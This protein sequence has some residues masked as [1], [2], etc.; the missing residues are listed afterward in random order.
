MPDWR[1]KLVKREEIADR[2]MA[3]HFEK[4]ANLQF[5]AG[6]FVDLSLIDPPEIDWAGSSRTLT[7]ASAPFENELMFAMRMRG[8]VFKRTLRNLPLGSEAL[9]DDPAGVFTLHEGCSRPAVFIAGG[10]GITPF[11][12][13]LRQAAFNRHPHRLH[14]FFSNRR[15]EDAAFFSEL[16]AMPKSNP[17]FRFIPVMTQMLRSKRTWEGETDYVGAAMLS[18][19]LCS[20]GEPI[21]YVSGPPAMIESMRQKLLE[22]GVDRKD[23]SA[24]SFDGY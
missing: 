5:T 21:Y 9:I 8:S 11:L 2:T 19:Y 18:K 15:P 1:I 6:Q 7:I 24:D 20:V 3:F 14:L 4:P 10:I 17:F 12:S 16:Q 22:L 23:I 13:I